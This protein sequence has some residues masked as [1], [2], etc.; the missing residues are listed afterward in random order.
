L[1]GSD[2][3]VHRYC[4]SDGLPGGEGSF[5]LCS[6][7]LVDALALAGRLDDARALFERILGRANDLGLFS[8]EV[9]SSTGELLGNYP[10]GFTHLGLIGA[11]VNLAKADR[12]GAEHE[13]QTE[14]ERAGKARHAAAAGSTPPGAPPLV[15]WRHV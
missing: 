6:L 14:S 12:H 15:H 13:A 2:G 7:W 10:Q 9:A 8:E 4:T 11:A 5:T 1:V 3:F